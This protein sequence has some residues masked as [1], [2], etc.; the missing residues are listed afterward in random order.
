MSERIGYGCVSTRDQSSDSQRDALEAAG[1][2]KVF[3]DEGSG[4]LDRRPELEKALEYVHAGDTLVITCLSRAARSVQNLLKLTDALRKRGIEL[5]V[6]TQG[7]DTGS[8]TGLLMFRLYGRLDE[9]QRELIVE[10]TRE[11]L[12]AARARGRK[13]GRPTALSNLQIDQ[14]RKMYDERGAN[15]E[16]AYTLQQIADTLDV[17]RATVFWHLNPAPDRSDGSGGFRQQGENA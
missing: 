5:Q 14:A 10:D 12:A 11:G 1:C 15:G 8:P 13:D 17:T 16:R 7:I 9:F 4:K 6:L 2:T 3:I